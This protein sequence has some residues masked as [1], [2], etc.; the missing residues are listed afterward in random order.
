MP[1]FCFSEKYFASHWDPLWFPLELWCHRLLLISFWTEGNLLKL[2]MFRIIVMQ[3]H[4]FVFVQ[5]FSQGHYIARHADF[6]QWSQMHKPWFFCFGFAI[7]A[8]LLANNVFTIFDVR[9]V[10]NGSRN[11]S[12]GRPL[13]HSKGHD[14]CKQVVFYNWEMPHMVKTICQKHRCAP[15][16]LIVMNHPWQAAWQLEDVLHDVNIDVY[17]DK[18]GSSNGWSW[19]T[20]IIKTY[21]RALYHFEKQWHTFD[22][23]NLIVSFQSKLLPLCRV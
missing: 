15:R 10:M 18:C 7:D 23:C 20:P 5:T 2:W 4:P 21:M 22:H 3:W 12:R 17:P 19:A 16:Q 11:G 14:L 8:S 9:L 13:G 6:Q 1:I